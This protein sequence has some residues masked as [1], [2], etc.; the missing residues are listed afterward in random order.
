[1]QTPLRILAAAISIAATHHLAA[2]T[3]PPLGTAPYFGVITLDVDATDTDHKVFRV[4]Q[5]LPV[6]P[7]PLALYYPQWVPGTHSPVGSVG[8]VA[9]LR[10]SAQGK[11]L[12]WTRNTLDVHA[13]HVEV[14]A[15]VSGLDIEFQYLGL[16]DSNAGRLEM[17]PHIL[18]VE[19][20][21]V[22]LYPA[23]HAASQIGV[24]ASLTLPPG[25]NYGTA[26]R[27]EG[28]RR[29]DK[30]EFQTV[31]LETLV[32]S[33]VF[34]GRHFQRYDL[35]PDAAKAGRAPVF[36]N[37]V[38][39]E[40]RQA[41][42]SEEQLAAHRA[43]VTQADRVFASRHYA[44]YD[45]LLA[46]SDEFGGIGLEHHQSSENG[47]KSYY[48]TDWA[49]SSPGRDLLSHEYT[50]S[51]NG[52]FRRPADLW[53]PH[54]NVPMQDSLLWV[55]EGQTQY[56]GAVLAARS[57][58]VSQADARED[59]AA[60]AAALEARVGRS[61]RNLQDTTNEP[62][63]SHSRWTRDWKNWQRSADYYDESML[64]WLEADMLI[65]DRSQYTRSLD[66]FARAFF[67]AEPKRVKPLTYTFDD[68]V[69][70]LNRVQPNDWASF[71]RTRLDRHD[72]SALLA[73]V[74]AAGWKLAWSDKPTDRYKLRQDKY[75][76]TDFAYSIGITLDKD[77]KLASVNWGSPAFEAGLSASVQLLAVNGIAY[78]AEK[79]QD[80]ITAAKDGAPIELLVKDNDRY[81]TVKV[82]WRGGLRYPK[83]ERIEGKPDRLSVLLAPLK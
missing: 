53:T 77:G 59:L 19:W 67:G 24:H 82:E 68:L 31:D 36:L 9:G 25:W 60:S 80:A 64:V 81:R 74:T 58:L 72:G 10:I 16:V 5:S 56:W 78:K 4:R 17:T 23:G 21:E 26:L 79:L 12:E 33:P 47:V 3:L 8:Q 15:G 35:D 42:A 29:G 76:Y 54:Y 61:W 70:E 51:W 66:D 18:G 14:P 30:I 49:K 57:G 48:F 2:Q 11:P 20:N 37:V 27:P 44:H 45:F 34:A 65:R 62:I 28:E 41:K 38:S 46:T 32:D 13:F 55:Y 1:M 75:E 43:L 52:K 40:A 50:H 39:D 71:L 6:K 83:L 69:R 73:G 63:V 7:G 22:L